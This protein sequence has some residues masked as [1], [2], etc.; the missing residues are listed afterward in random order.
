MQ[1]PACSGAGEWPQVTL[2]ANKVGP[3][4]NPQETYPYY[5]LPFCKVFFQ[6]PPKS[7][8]LSNW[9]GGLVPVW[10]SGGVGISGSDRT[11]QEAPNP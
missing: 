7:I 5:M 10:I 2:W 3:Y 8:G 11:N 4:E 9:F 1:F 6:N